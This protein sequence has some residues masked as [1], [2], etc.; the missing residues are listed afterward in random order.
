[1]Q[2]M[3]R[4]EFWIKGS[5]GDEYKVIFEKKRNDLKVVCNCRAGTSRNYCKH[6]FSL[7][8]GEISNLLSPNTE[9]VEWLR[10]FMA[11]T[12]L[13]AAYRQVVEAVQ[14]YE[15]AKQHLAA[16]KKQLRRIMYL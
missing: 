1:M 7:M 16:A 6:F 10:I 2:P 14:S 11:G 12:K 15:A 13:E 4:L 3:T 5:R 8:D 9:D